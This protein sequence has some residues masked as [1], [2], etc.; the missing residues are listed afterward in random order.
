MK[1]SVKADSFPEPV[2]L[3]EIISERPSVIDGNRRRAYNPGL[4]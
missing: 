1:D 3:F 4:L 2:R